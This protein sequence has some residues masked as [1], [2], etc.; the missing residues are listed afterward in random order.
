MDRIISTLL[1]STAAAAPHNVEIR[2]TNLEIRNAR[3]PRSADRSLRGI[4]GFENFDAR[5]IGLFAVVICEL[6]AR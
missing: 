1:S 6:V 2:L 4:T 3:G 5:V